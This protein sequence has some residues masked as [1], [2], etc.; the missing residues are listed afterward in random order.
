MSENLLSNTQKPITINTGIFQGHK[1]QSP[2]ITG[3]HKK[4]YGEIMDTF[5][6]QLQEAWGISP[7]DAATVETPPD[8]LDEGARIDAKGNPVL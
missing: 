5:K 7:E 3:K 1:F 2:R 6:M 4:A 8:L